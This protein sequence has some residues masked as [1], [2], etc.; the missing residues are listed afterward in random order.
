MTPITV[1]DFTEAASID[2]WFPIDDGVMGGCS[3]SRLVHDPAG[4]AVFEG[5][6]SLENGGGFA[7][8]R[9]RPDDLGV[10]GAAGFGLEVRGDGRRYKLQ[11]RTDDGFDGLSYQ[12]GFEAPSD[13]WT[14][15]RWPLT[16]FIAT[17]RGRPVADAPPLDPA[18]VRQIGLLIADRQAG[19]FRLALR[20]LSAW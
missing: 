6:V 2:V 19:P 15:W 9:R 17:F 5:V 10:P 14:P 16:A 1:L 7:S 12:V 11:L 3:R 4:F 18:R 20:S 13:G 8:V